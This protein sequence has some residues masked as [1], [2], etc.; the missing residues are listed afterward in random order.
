[1]AEVVAVVCIVEEGCMEEEGM[2]DVDN[3]AEDVV[4]AGVDGVDDCPA[5]FPQLRMRVRHE[6]SKRPP[7]LLSRFRFLSAAAHMVLAAGVTMV[8]SWRSNS[9]A[10]ESAVRRCLAGPSKK[11]NKCCESESQRVRAV[12]SA[13]ANEMNN[14]CSCTVNE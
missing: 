11:I 7:R 3:G 5:T 1:M 14:L 12:P 2:G 9:L 6:T 8:N 13:A 10:A 4:G